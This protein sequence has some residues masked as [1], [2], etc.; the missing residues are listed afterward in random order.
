MTLALAAIGGALL[1]Y[2][3]VQRQAVRRRDALLDEPD[4]A[5]RQAGNVS[6]I[7]GVIVIL[8][9]AATI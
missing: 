1:A 3:L 8:A 9:A 2:G 6:I 7:V 5:R 4:P